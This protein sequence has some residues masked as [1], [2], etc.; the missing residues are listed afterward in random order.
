[1]VVGERAPV[2]IGL[3]REIADEIVARVLAA[4]DQVRG[5]VLPDLVEAAH[6]RRLV[7]DAVL[8]HG[9]DPAAEAVAVAFWNAQHVGDKLDRDML[10]V[11]EGGVATALGD[12]AV[13]QLVADL[14][15]LGDEL[16]DGLRRER[17]QQ[18]HAGQPVPRRI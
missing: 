14:A 5:E 1:M 13:D 3:Q 15:R 17:R 16:V 12:E 8:E 10:G 9:L 2:G 18:H 4:L 11:L 7:G 6:H